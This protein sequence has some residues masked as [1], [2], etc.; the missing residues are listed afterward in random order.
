MRADA[1]K[2]MRETGLLVSKAMESRV[3]QDLGEA[4]LEMTGGQDWE[5]Q[6]KLLYR[7]LSAVETKVEQRQVPWEEAR[8]LSQYTGPGSAARDT[9]FALRNMSMA[10]ACIEGRFRDEPGYSAED[11]FEHCI[12][13]AQVIAEQVIAE[14]KRTAAGAE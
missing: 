11:H 7:L 8:R 6:A 14:T 2:R 1:K 5:E 13:T 9:A 12:S 4:G 10:Q 3:V